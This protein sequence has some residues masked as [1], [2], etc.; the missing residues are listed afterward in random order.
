M[1]L[2]APAAIASN[3]DMPSHVSLN[4]QLRPAPADL[5]SRSTILL[6]L[7]IFLQ[8]PARK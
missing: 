8:K 7:A 2:R 5:T 4:D 3:S 1:P 6:S